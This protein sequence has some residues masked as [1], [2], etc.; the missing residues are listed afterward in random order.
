MTMLSLLQRSMENLL[1]SAYWGLA[2]TSPPAECWQ[3][4]YCLGILALYV[5]VVHFSLE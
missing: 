4:L 1:N 2:M 3:P 5:Q